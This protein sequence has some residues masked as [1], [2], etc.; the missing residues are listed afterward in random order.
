MV[1]IATSRSSCSDSP[2]VFVGSVPVGDI[3][4]G[5]DVFALFGEVQIPLVGPD[6]K[7]PG[8]YKADIDGAF[9]YE[10]FSDTGSAWVPK[11]GFTLL[12]IKDVALRGSFSK[13]FIAPTLYQTA[14][15]GQQRVHELRFNFG[16][17]SEQAQSS[18]A[19]T[20]TLAAPGRTPT[21]PVS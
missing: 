8:I 1:S 21:P 15:T 11:V 4:M 10:S 16:A 12:P 9:R 13:S 7:I 6:M 17:G 14:R 19:P 18:A 2:E 5:R 20:R 3:D